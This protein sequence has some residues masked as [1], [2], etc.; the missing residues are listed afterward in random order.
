MPV[1]EADP[2]RKQYFEDLDCP[3]DVNI[4]TEDA[5][6]Y[7]W[8]PKYRWVYNKLMIAESQ[9][10]ECGPHGLIPKSFPV[11][12]KPVYN[13]RGMGAGSRKFKDETTYYQRQRPGHMWS[14]FLEGEH[15][16]TDVVVVDGESK[17]WR[18][19]QGSPLKK[20]TFDYWTIK[21][22]SY[23]EVEKLCSDW[24]RKNLNGYTGMLNLET[25]GAKIIEAHLRFSDQW[26]DL[27]GKGWTDALVGLYK[28]RTWGFEDADRKEGYSVVLFGAHGVSY[29]H[30]PQDIQNSIRSHSKVSSLQITFY[31]DKDP[32]LHSMPPG[33]F[34]LAVLNGYD[35]DTLLKFRETLALSFWTAQNLLT[36]SK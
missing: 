15:I 8:N 10:L 6:A 17:W 26:P 23:P 36:Q 30:P 3:A 14:T 7:E 4:P 32:E 12:S 31:E 5:D 24:I 20:G 22:D 34:R 13:M 2:W 25:I 11:F 35:L 28:N 27:Y 1:C 9:N 16:S 21:A 33:G 29:K 19:T 18:H